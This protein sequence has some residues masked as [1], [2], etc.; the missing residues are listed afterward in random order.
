MPK[1]CGAGL[2]STNAHVSTLVAPF[3]ARLRS[4]QMTTPVQIVTDASSTVDVNAEDEGGSNAI[5]NAASRGDNETILYLVSK[6]GDV[7]KVKR[8]GLNRFPL[9]ISS[10]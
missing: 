4:R 9:V 5:H 6:G 7:I 10:A 8:C 1:E 2:R 3:D